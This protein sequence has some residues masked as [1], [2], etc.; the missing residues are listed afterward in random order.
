MGFK[1]T[2]KCKYRTTSLIM[3]RGYTYEEA[4]EKLQKSIGL[5]GT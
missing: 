1:T 4:A 5:T 3:Y 2:Q